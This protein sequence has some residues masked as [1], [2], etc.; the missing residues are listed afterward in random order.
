MTLRLPA[1]LLCACL[2]ASPG[3]A[4]ACAEVLRGDAVTLERD[5]GSARDGDNAGVQVLG[6]GW[7]RAAT[8]TK[9]GGTTHDTTLV[10]ELDGEPLV[11]ATFATLRDG[12]RQVQSSA[13]SVTL[14]I[15]GDTSTLTVWYP[16]ELKFRALANLRVDVREAGVQSLRVSAVLNKPAPHEHVPGSPGAVAGLPA[17]K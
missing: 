1:A 17:F 13:L 4:M 6:A 12:W 14:A 16:D 5:H 15:V 3:G 10:V 2:A 9:V 11:S 8:V 7:F